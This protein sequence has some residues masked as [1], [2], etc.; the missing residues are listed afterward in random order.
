MFETVFLV[1]KFS[2]ISSVASSLKNECFWHLAITLF[3][4]CP[5]PSFYNRFF[6]KLLILQPNLLIKSHNFLSKL[7]ISLP[8]ESQS[9]VSTR[10]IMES[11]LF[12]MDK[13]ACNVE[14]MPCHSILSA[15][16]PSVQKLR[17][18][19]IGAKTARGSHWPMHHI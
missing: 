6:C 10:K 15:T 9:P 8:K 19:P 3:W 13:F 7:K 1:H 5:T 11:W 2:S 18:I 4:G 14:P 17:R 16:S 12:K